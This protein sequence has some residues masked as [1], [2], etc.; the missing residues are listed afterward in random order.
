VRAPPVFCMLLAELNPCTASAPNKKNL[1]QTS[2][3]TGYIAESQFQS[4]LDVT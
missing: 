2:F 1:I 4:L 3:V